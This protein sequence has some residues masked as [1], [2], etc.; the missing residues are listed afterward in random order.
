MVENIDWNATNPGQTAN[1]ALNHPEV[2]QRM[3]ETGEGY[4]KAVATQQGP[5]TR[6]MPVGVAETTQLP[7]RD[8]RGEGGVKW[9]F[10]RQGR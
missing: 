8:G 5:D 2:V 3:K 9:S 1:I 10:P 4:L 7:A 6:P